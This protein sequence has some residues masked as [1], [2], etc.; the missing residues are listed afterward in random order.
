MESVCGLSPK[1]DPSESTSVQTVRVSNECWA[2]KSTYCAGPTSVIPSKIGGQ[3][4]DYN[5]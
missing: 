5:F 1:K 3:D 4:I 2:Y